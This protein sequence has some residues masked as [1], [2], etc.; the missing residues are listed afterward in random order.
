MTY[1]EWLAWPDGESKQTEWVDGEVIVFV[2]PTWFHQDALG[3]LHILLRLYARFFDLGAV[4]AAPFEMRLSDRSSR[5][6]DLLFVARDHL[7]RLTVERLIGPA[8]LAV[9]LVSEGSVRRDR[10]EKFAEYAL[11]GVP[12]YWLLD[13]RPGRQR[14]EFYRLGDEGTYEAVPLDADGRYH[15]AVLPNFWFRPD[16][17]W[18]DPP[19]DPLAC[20]LEIAPQILSGAPG[21]T[22]AQPPD[23]T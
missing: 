10:L 16:W 2:P 7:D 20:L 13:P 14:S 5:E 6:P 9:E 19:P 22:S 17:L 11:A 15:A 18:Q 23:R 8:D 12:E 3:F 4:V 21:A 1:E